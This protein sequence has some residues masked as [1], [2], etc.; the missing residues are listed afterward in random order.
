MVRFDVDGLAA[1]LRGRRVGLVAT[2][3]SWTLA[4]GHLLDAL[5][6]RR[7]DLR[8]LVALEHGFRGEL[9][10]GADVGRYTDAASG[11]PVLSFYGSGRVT[12]EAMFAEADVLVFQVQDVTHRAY[13]FHQAMA[14][15]L[16]A[17]A[18]T[19]KT[20]LLLDRPTPLAHLGPD[21]LTGTQ[22]FPL[23]FPL[24][25][26]L[27]MGELANW[28]AAANGWT[29]AL[30]VAPMPGWRRR[31]RWASTG[32]PW[33][34]P[35]PNLPTVTS[36]YAY[37]CSGLVQHTSVSEGRGTCK[38]FEY[39]GAP[40]LDGDRLAAALNALRLPGVA[41]RALHFQPGFNKFA[42]Q[43]CSGVHLLIRDPGRI[44]PPL[45]GLALLRECARQAP[46]EFALQ[47]AFAAWLDNGAWTPERLANLDLAAVHERMRADA[48]AFR[49][50]TDPCRLY[51][52]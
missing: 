31:D 4:D 50:R 22:F 34:P 14:E 2:P 42:G 1:R 52:D 36:V 19:G 33:I 37:A 9:P 44:A 25:P 18:R 49:Q 13:T 6:A 11:L 7:V 12:P 45:V 38:P 10:D 47:P 24:L 28:L 40:F 3:A 26:G 21:G 51:P 41:F 35:S 8:V 20:L 29:T 30:E 5:L 32:L 16:A 43:V 46:A 48:A 15:L 17:A 23:P 39:V 27:T